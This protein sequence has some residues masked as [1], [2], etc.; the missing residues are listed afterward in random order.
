[1]L[2]IK[3]L[4]LKCT[5]AKHPQQCVGEEPTTLD[6]GQKFQGNINFHQFIKNLNHV[7]NLAGSLYLYI[8]HCLKL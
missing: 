1:M 4:T 3:K 2:P 6:V 8:C 7:G 5:V